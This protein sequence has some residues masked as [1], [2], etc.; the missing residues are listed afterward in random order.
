V[1]IELKI[2]Q[3]EQRRLDRK[4]HRMP[5]DVF[6]KH[7][8]KATNFAMTPV[9]KTA[10]QKVPVDEGALK[11][12][13]K[14]KRKVYK[15]N[16]TVWQ[17]VGS[18]KGLAPHAML[19]ELGHRQVTGGTV[20]RSNGRLRGTAKN[21]KRTGKGKVVGFVAPRPFLRPAFE[22]EKDNVLRRYRDKL[23]KGVLAEAKG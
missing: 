21:K 4:I 12:S 2:D 6:R 18:V 11:D 1:K 20:A 9:L 22:T 5:E 3:R 14:K 10:K 23:K 8:S 15:K 7:V 17:G 19:V 13:L 16:Y